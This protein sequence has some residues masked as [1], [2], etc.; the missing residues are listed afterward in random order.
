MLPLFE[1]CYRFY[2]TNTSMY[3]QSAK[4][5]ID[6]EHPWKRLIIKQTHFQT[7][8]QNGWGITCICTLQ[9]KR[10][11]FASYF[12][13]HNI[14][15]YMDFGNNIYLEQLTQYERHI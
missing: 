5:F 7:M 3:N 13:W 14:K 1:S 15:F 11:S 6:F 9:I 12:C 4:R 2:C 10:G 8:V